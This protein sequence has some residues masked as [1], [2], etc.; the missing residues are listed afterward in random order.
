MVTSQFMKMALT[1]QISE[2]KEAVNKSSAS[3]RA[4][5]ESGSHVLRTHVQCLT[6]MMNSKEDDMFYRFNPR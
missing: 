1:K 6:S 3:I 4:I 2:L 5:I